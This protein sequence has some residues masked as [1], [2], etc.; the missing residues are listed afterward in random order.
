MRKQTDSLATETLALLENWLKAVHDVIQHIGTTRGP[1]APYYC[2][3]QSPWPL[4]ATE[5]LCRDTSRVIEYLKKR[6]ALVVRI[7]L[8]RTAQAATIWTAKRATVIE[9]SKIK[10]STADAAVEAAHELERFTDD[11]LPEQK[12]LN[13]DLRIAEG[14]I[15]RA[16]FP[17]LAE[18]LGDGDRF[19]T[20]RNLIRWALWV[21]RAFADVIRDWQLPDESA[22]FPRL[23]ERDDVRTGWPESHERWELVNVVSPGF[24]PNTDETPI[25]LAIAE[26]RRAG[27]LDVALPLIKE[28][29]NEINRFVLEAARWPQ[30]NLQPSRTEHLFRAVNELEE[31]VGSEAGDP[32]SR[33]YSKAT[34]ADVSNP[35][36]PARGPSA[37]RMKREVAE[38]RIAQHLSRRP[39]DTAAETAKGVECSVGVVGESKAWKL[40]QERL[41]IARREGID[42][43]AVKLDERAV[44]AAGGGMMR[45]LHYARQ[46]AADIGREIDERDMELFR[47]ID[48]YQKD[49][50]DVDPEDVA[51][52]VGCTAGDVE[53]RQAALNRLVAEQTEDQK[54]DV[55]VE[56]HNSK[57]GMRQKWFEKR[58]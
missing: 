38:P 31:L 26:A 44:N 43:G 17:L 10:H 21:E 3:R 39:H 18:R 25:K 32:V 2:I 22:S 40:N 5:V 27:D 13:L 24:I 23:N 46:Q 1:H 47:R 50:P 33:L 45:Q 36:K 56:D 37:G 6:H 9:F 53:R 48:D 11:R 29:N 58:V 35:A 57:R 30:G 41:K 12:R 34:S 8:E 42:P 52:A 20:R 4:E 49:N 19:L 14:A 16:S 55:A 15:W 54:E 28:L 51:S 7:P